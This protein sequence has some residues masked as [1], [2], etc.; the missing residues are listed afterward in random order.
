MTMRDP[1]EDTPTQTAVATAAPVADNVVAM[2]G[3]AM[4]PRQG[5]DQRRRNERW[6]LLALLAALVLLMWGD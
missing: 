5:R 1:C 3:R 2:P 4:L 6:L